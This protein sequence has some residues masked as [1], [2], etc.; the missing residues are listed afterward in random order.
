MTPHNELML[1][2]V[3][4]ELSKLSER[5]QKIIIAYYI[6]GLTMREIATYLGLSSGDVAKTLKSRCFKTLLNYV[7]T[8]TA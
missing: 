7:K 4:K 8:E 2:K 6:D 3:K 5:C 1:A